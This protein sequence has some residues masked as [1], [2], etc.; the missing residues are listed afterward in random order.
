MGRHLCYELRL[1]RHFSLDDV[2]ERVGC[3]VSR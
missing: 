1:L 3:T 2:A